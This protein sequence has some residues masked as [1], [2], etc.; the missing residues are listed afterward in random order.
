MWFLCAGN[1]DLSN[2]EV[3]GGEVASLTTH[4]ASASSASLKNPE[5]ASACPSPVARVRAV[6]ILPYPK[7]KLAEQRKRR[8]Q[9]AEVLTSSPYKKAVEDRANTHTPRSASRKQINGQRNK[10]QKVDRR[11]RKNE[12]CTDTTPCGVCGGKYND[13]YRKRNGKKW[14]AC[15][16]CQLWYHND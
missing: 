14:I 9:R 16:V 15:S 5:P 7:C 8:A 11:T 12:D 1:C 2:E 4:Q 10:K 13:D 6:D 3:S